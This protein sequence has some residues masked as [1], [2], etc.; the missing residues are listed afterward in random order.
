MEDFKF[1]WEGKEYSIPHNNIM[2]LIA[3]VENVITL[4]ELEDAVQRGTAP[5]GKLSMAFGII[6][7]HA[8]V[9]VKDYEIYKS[10][11]SENS[12]D[13]A[14]AAASGLIM[15]MVPPDCLPKGN[16]PSKKK[17]PSESDTSCEKPTSPP[18]DGD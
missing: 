12:A 4:P 16:A 17:E 1:T 8:G 9:R 3:T 5:L 14:V 7:R 10:M 6:L 2:K 11:F 13:N 18:S 15:L